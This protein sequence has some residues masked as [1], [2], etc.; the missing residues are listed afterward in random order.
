LLREIFKESGVSPRHTGDP[1]PVVLKKLLQ[2]I[3]GGKILPERGMFIGEHLINL[4]I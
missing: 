3:H 4:Q 2:I 1:P